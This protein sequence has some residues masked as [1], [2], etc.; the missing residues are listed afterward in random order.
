MKQPCNP[1]SKIAQVSFIHL[2]VNTDIL[3]DPLCSYK[4]IRIEGVARW[5]LRAGA[6]PWLL[7]PPLVLVGEKPRFCSGV[8]PDG[9]EGRQEVP[10][11]FG[12]LSAIRITADSVHPVVIW[13]SSHNNTLLLTLPE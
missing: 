8:P 11:G 1:L 2:F 7:H 13:V 6:P 10:P 5:T 4:L 12:A 3:S 9:I